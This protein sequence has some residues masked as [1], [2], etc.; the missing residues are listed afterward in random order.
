MNRSRLPLMPSAAVRREIRVAEHDHPGLRLRGVLGRLLRTGLSPAAGVAT[1][2]DARP[3]SRSA[4]AC[5][6]WPRRGPTFPPASTVF[7]SVSAQ[8]SA[9][10]STNACAKR[11]P[12]P[13][14]HH[15]HR[16]RQRVGGQ[17]V[18][19]LRRSGATGSS[20]PPAPSRRCRA[21]GPCR[22]RRRRRCCRRRSPSRARAPIRL[23][24]GG[25]S[26]FSGGSRSSISLP[27]L[28]RYAFSASISPGR[29]SAFG[30]GNHDDG[31]VVRHVGL[32]RE[33]Q[34]LDLVVVARQLRRRCRCSRSARR[35]TCPSRRGPA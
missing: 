6:P 3:R 18:H 7:T 24:S 11:P 34:L 5:R 35:R 26:A 17:Q 28:A 22:S 27:P 30:P 21:G 9:L 19:V 33:R 25:S 8:L 31:G 29:K 16:P 23:A 4:L 13:P 20:P 32:L 2:A 15:R 1:G 14:G 12:T 10:V